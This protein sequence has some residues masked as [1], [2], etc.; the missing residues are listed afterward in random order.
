VQFLNYL[1]NAQALPSI[2]AVKPFKFLVILAI[3][4]EQHPLLQKDYTARALIIKT[5]TSKYFCMIVQNQFFCTHTESPTNYN[6]RPT[7]QMPR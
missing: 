2:M 7:V 6:D 1:F 4:R 5:L 3:T